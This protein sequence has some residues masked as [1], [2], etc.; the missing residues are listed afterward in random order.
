MH[1]ELLAGV[2]HKLEAC[3]ATRA[4]AAKS[5]HTVLSSLLSTD[6]PISEVM[7]RDRWIDEMRNNPRIYPDGWY[8]PP[9]SGIGV[10]FGTEADYGR[11]NYDTLRRGGEDK[12]VK[13]SNWPSK[14]IVLDR[15]TGI[16]YIYASPVDRA[17]GMI[18]DW[19]MTIYFGH[20]PDIIDHL[21]LC[22][23][24]NH[25]VLDHAQVG[26]T[27][28]SLTNYAYELFS[29]QGLSN[30]VT[31]ATDRTGVNIG[32]TVPGSYEDWTSEDIEIFKT[33]DWKKIID[34]ISHKRRFLNMTED[35]QIRRGMAVTI[36][37]RLTKPSK[38]SIPMSSFHTIGIINTD[39]SKELLTN[40]NEMFDLVGMSYMLDNDL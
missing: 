36:E 37:Q 40:F 17:T 23:R 20:N 19:G 39:G 32:H 11:M 2:E 38:K 9:P 1:A 30:N 12:S 21:K 26:T 7:V 24:L 6:L 27:F 8:M 13:D 22:L 3:K 18:A 34:M 5:F 25:Q 35:L 10:L 33:G 31:S 14:D 29:K 28:A 16:I 15:K 4:W